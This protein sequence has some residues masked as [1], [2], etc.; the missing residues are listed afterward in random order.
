MLTLTHYIFSCLNNFSEMPSKIL[1]P[2]AEIFLC[3]G[4]LRN[5]DIPPDPLMYP[6]SDIFHFV[7]LLSS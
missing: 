7:C 5:V 3:Y 1:D 6:C 2:K 4:L